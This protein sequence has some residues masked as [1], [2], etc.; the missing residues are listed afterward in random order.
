MHTN[1]RIPWGLQCFA[2]YG[3]CAAVSQRSNAKIPGALGLA[4]GQQ[5]KDNQRWVFPGLGLV[6]W[7]L[8][9]HQGLNLSNKVRLDQLFLHIL[10]HP[11][12]CLKN[13][14]SVTGSFEFLHTS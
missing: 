7:I 2:G 8:G 14:F 12:T 13:V 10:T 5:D 11:Y 3:C 4:A 9:S 1:L 6:I